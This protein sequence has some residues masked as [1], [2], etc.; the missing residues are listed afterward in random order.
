GNSP[1]R[2]VQAHFPGRANVHGRA[3]AD[4]FD[5][6]QDLDRGRV[7]LVPGDLGGRSLFVRHESCVSPQM[8][9]D[10]WRCCD[11]RVVLGKAVARKVPDI[12]LPI[13][14][15]RSKNLARAGTRRVFQGSI[16]SRSEKFGRTRRSLLFSPQRRSSNVA[17]ERQQR[18]IPALA[19][20]AEHIVG[21]NKM[22]F[23]RN[24][25]N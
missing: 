13:G 5:A 6:A 23:G 11:S 20:P 3:L 2:V 24:L 19:G 10:S 8:A 16:P 18:L 9:S 22:P 21:T 1:D 17:T 12:A 15:Y 7:I 4:S 25:N 14:P